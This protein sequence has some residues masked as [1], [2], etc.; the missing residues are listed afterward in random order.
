MKKMDEDLL[1]QLKDTI[2]KTINS[3]I[4][5]PHMTEYEREVKEKELV[6]F[7]QGKGYE[8]FVEECM[9]YVIGKQ[10]EKILMMELT[11]N[12][13]YF[14]PFKMAEVS[15]IVFY[16]LQLISKKYLDGVP[17]TKTKK[18][19]A[20]KQEEIEEDSDEDTE[21]EPKPPPDFSFL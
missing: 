17:K 21:E 15:E 19:V 12:T 14:T 10:W 2:L 3:G 8:V 13:L 11:R 1:K 9:I 6:I 20:K 7:L 5:Y 4:A 18:K 16:I